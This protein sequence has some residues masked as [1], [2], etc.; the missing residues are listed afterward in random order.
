MAVYN[1][2]HTVGE[3]IDQVLKVDLGGRVIELIIVESNSTDG[4]REI[5]QS[6]RGSSERSRH[7]PG[8]AARQG[9][10]RSRRPRPRPSATWS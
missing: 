1:E 6:V 9:P 10:R 2:A 8:P 5:V 7:L 3:V 4:T